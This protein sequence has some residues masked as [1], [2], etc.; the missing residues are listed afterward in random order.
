MFD[1]IMDNVEFSIA[2]FVSAMLFSAYSKKWTTKKN[3]K[4]VCST[5]TSHAKQPKNTN[6]IPDADNGK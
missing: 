2:V 5:E 1:W 3:R 4:K 6:V